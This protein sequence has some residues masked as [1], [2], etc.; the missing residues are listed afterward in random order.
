MELTEKLLFIACQK[1]ELTQNEFE[2]LRRLKPKWTWNFTG[3]K[4]CGKK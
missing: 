3:K 2:N 4:R 1:R